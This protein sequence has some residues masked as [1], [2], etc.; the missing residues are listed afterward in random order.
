[1]LATPVIS[2]S[3]PSAEKVSFSIS[4]MVLPSSV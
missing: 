1:V 3:T 4:P 2:M